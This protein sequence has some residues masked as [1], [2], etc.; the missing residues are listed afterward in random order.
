MSQGERYEDIVH[1]NVPLLKLI[2]EKLWKDVFYD[3]ILSSIVKS[4]IGTPMTFNEIYE[5]ST[6][7]IR[8]IKSKSSIY[9]YLNS[10]IEN[11]LVIEVGHR[12]HPEKTISKRL[13][14]RSAEII[15]FENADEN[16]W[17][18][19]DRDGLALVIGLIINRHFNDEMPNA[20][21]IREKLLRI[22]K[23]FSQIR[24]A[25]IRNY[26][27]SE[28]GKKDFIDRIRNLEYKDLYALFNNL[29][30]IIG[31]LTNGIHLNLKTELNLCFHKKKEKDLLQTHQ[32][33]GQKKHD[34]ILHTP[35]LIKPID[36][37]IYDKVVRNNENIV[38]ILR[39]LSSGPLTLNE[40]HKNHHKMIIERRKKNNTET[41]T[42]KPKSRNTVYK[43]VQ[44][45]I[46]SGFISEVG[47]RPIIH[48]SAT[49]KL[50]SKSAEIF[51]RIEHRKEYWDS[52]NAK[53]VSNIIGLILGYILKKESF[54]SSN[55]HSVLLKFVSDQTK[56]LE[57][58]LENSNSFLIV[59]NIRQYVL[60]GGQES[61][62][63]LYTLGLVEWLLK[64]DRV[65]EFRQ[66][67]LQCFVGDSS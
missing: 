42:A 2:D 65:E 45:L 17:S 51:Y 52:D 4:F 20:S 19:E 61:G 66:E 41:E 56:S 3:E 13:Y 1:T 59:E 22:E 6:T 55:L 15:L 50:Y 23:K 8:K 31:I 54:K 25:T 10:L 34:L 39:M 48:Q 29:G 64:L 5:N 30:I 27:D 57:Q 60:V 38:V 44:E 33:E 26:L 24:E 28:N 49:Q 9:R 62:T 37:R 32:N 40:I 12:I 16:I 67:L 47:R 7:L 36:A 14:Y 35:V 63:F 11:N 21:M 53:E 43:Y 46:K 58:A 18:S